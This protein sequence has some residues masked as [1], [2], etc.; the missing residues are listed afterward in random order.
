M[1]SLRSRALAAF[2][3]ALA[4]PAVATPVAHGAGDLYVSLGDSYARGSQPGHTSGDDGFA[5]QLPALARARGYD[6]EVVNFGCGGAT[7]A[8]LV[9]QVGCANRKVYAP[10]ERTYPDSTQLEAATR[11]IAANRDRLALVTVVVGLNDLRPCL[12]DEALASCVARQSE[13]TGANVGAAARAVREAAGP[14]VPVVGL[15]YPNVHLGAWVRPGRS[16]GHQRARRMAAAF[17]RSLNPALRAGYAEGKASFADA[18]RASGGYGQMDGERRTTGF[19]RVPAPVADICRISWACD[20][21]DIHLK[22]AGYRLMARL[23]AAK[24]PRR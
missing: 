17:E 3:C 16:A 22:R 9:G 4:L 12:R 23:V 5:Y 2:A 10:G 24:L 21:A 8:S 14:G 6:L 18:T 20:E 15:A 11:F 13:L 1:P 7:S 19:G